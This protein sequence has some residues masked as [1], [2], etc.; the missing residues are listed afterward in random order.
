MKR[1]TLA[2]LPLTLAAACHGSD[3]P[4]PTGPSV[5]ASTPGVFQA[6]RYQ[7]LITG[8]TLGGS[9]TGGGVS[10]DDVNTGAAHVGTV[11]LQPENGDWVARSTGTNDTLRVRFTFANF[12]DSH[13]FTGS[14]QGSAAPLAAGVRQLPAVDVA[15]ARLSGDLVDPEQGLGTVEAFG[16]IAGQ[17]V[18]T[19]PQGMVTCSGGNLILQR[20]SGL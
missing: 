10:V 4:N 20:A 5:A 12:P 16:T 9:C 7:M 13:A 15:G 8:G 19:G 18:F 11:N 17:L 1:I 3:H 6:G 2:V 14:V